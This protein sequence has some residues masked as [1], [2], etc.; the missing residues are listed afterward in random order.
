MRSAAPSF[1]HDVLD[2]DLDGVLG[3]RDVLLA[4]V[5]PAMEAR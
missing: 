4:G 2:V 1:F 3:G 5:D